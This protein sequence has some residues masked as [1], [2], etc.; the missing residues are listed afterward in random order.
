MGWQVPLNA[1]AS[2]YLHSLWADTVVMFS[3]ISL[4]CRLLAH[5]AELLPSDVEQQIL[6]LLASSLF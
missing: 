6:L 2:C 1:A 4:T 3:S 5:S